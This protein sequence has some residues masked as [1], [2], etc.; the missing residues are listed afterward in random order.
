MAQREDKNGQLQYLRH[1][2]PEHVLTYAPTR[3][4]KGVGLVV[5]HLAFLET[6]NGSG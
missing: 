2:G 3:S 5:P 1:N 6:F 4:G